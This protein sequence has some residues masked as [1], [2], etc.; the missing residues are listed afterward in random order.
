[1][2]RTTRATTAGVTEGVVEAEAAAAEG[3]ELMEGNRGRGEG[4]IIVGL[5]EVQHLLL[6]P[7]LS[8]T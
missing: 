2:R 6:R 8:K 7:V 5:L 3:M 4:L 1:M